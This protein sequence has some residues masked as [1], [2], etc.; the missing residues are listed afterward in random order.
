[1]STTYPRGPRCVSKQ[2]LA[3]TEKKNNYCESCEK[4]VFEIDQINVI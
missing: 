3:L 4:T 1:M 2:D